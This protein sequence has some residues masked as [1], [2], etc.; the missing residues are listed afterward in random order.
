MVMSIQ[1]GV[2][3]FIIDRHLPAGGM[4]S[5]MGLFN[6]LEA[7]GQSPDHAW[8]TIREAMAL[9]WIEPGLVAGRMEVTL[10]GYEAARQAADLRR[11][12]PCGPADRMTAS[13]SLGS[14]A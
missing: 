5:P 8:A 13:D 14:P 12:H 10:R 1:S 7:R 9:R 4:F 2:V 3:D 11:D 6:Y